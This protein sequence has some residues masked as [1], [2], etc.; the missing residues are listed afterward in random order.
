[1]GIWFDQRPRDGE[2]AV[3][4]GEVPYA[5]YR[6]R[7]YDPDSLPWASFLDEDSPRLVHVK[8]LER[9]QRKGERVRLSS[10]DMRVVLAAVRAGVGKALLPICV[11]EEEPDLVRLD[12]GPPE[13]IR[14]L[15]L[16]LHPDSVQTQ[17]VQA[18]TRWL[19][20]EVERAFGAPYLAG[21]TT[22]T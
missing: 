21:Q 8:A 11:A 1:M 3:R 14:V 10:G 20:E 5:F 2:F 6:C 17:R 18:V 15:H 22:L 19:R 4:L 16:H 7:H 13:L 9:T 12:D